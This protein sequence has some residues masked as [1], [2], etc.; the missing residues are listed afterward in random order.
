[1]RRISCRP[2]SKRQPRGSSSEIPPGYK[3][4]QQKQGN[5]RYGDVV[6]WFQLLD[7]AREQKK[8]LIFITADTKEDWWTKEGRPRPELIHEMFLDAKTMFHIYKPAQF[9]TY[10]SRFL[11]PKKEAKS[12]EKAAMELREIESQRQSRR[13]TAEAFAKVLKAAQPNPMGTG[14]LADLLNSVKPDPA[15]TA[16]LH[17]SNVTRP[18]TFSALDELT[19]L[20][21]NSSALEELNKSNWAST[22]LESLTKPSSILSA[23]LERLTKSNAISSYLEDLAKPSSILSARIEEINR[24]NALASFYLEDLAKPDSTLSAQLEKIA[25]S[26]AIVSSFVQEPTNPN[27]LEPILAL[28]QPS[29]KN[30]EIRSKPAEGGALPGAPAEKMKEQSEKAQGWPAEKREK[31]E[32]GPKSEG[33]ETD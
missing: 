1:M 17:L 8:P 25:K 12:I 7:L 19:R 4:E 11:D 18:N 9:V 29:E 6:L 21:L 27:P 13:A 24:T 31:N 26:N 14:T 20:N 2:L 10:A 32:P 23:Q 3:D 15:V 16:A 28:T 33:P 30:P 5:R 22:Y